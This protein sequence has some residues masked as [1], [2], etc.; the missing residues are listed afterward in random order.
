M[1]QDN[2]NNRKRAPQVSAEQQ[3]IE[4]VAKALW[5]L[6]SFP[7]TRGK[8]AA[9]RQ[10]LVPAAAAKELGLHWEVVSLYS[11]TPNTFAV[12]ISEADK[13]LDGALK[14]ANF[15]GT[16]MGER[17]KASQHVFDPYLYS[18]VWEAHKLR[19][20]LA[21]EVGI[22]VNGQEVKQALHAFEQGLL[23]LG[24]FVH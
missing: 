24:V 13:L 14:A 18:H 23:A 5:T 3:I 8:K 9:K 15:A 6:V 4:A 16:T 22:S 17:L 20:R 19:N 10:G 2:R 11:Q 1:A 21:H 7:F 12:A